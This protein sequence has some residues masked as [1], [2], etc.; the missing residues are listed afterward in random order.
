MRRAVI[1][2]VLLLISIHTIFG[3]RKYKEIIFNE[4]DVA[5][6]L[7]NT[8]SLISWIEAEV[9]NK[10]GGF[11]LVPVKIEHRDDW[12]DGLYLNVADKYS[13]YRIHIEDFMMGIGMGS[14]V[15][16]IPDGAVFWIVGN[17]GYIFD[18]FKSNSDSS[19]VF[20]PTNHHVELEGFDKSKIYILKE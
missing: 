10:D 3:Q 1:A 11:F 4:W 16:G 20:T 6:D 8:E 13:Q 9:N 12:R 19:I 5:F 17:W 2:S 15:Q 18:V 7:K 14:R